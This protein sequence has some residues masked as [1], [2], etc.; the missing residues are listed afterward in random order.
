MLVSRGDGGLVTNGL[1]A[2]ALV[3]RIDVDV[4]DGALEEP[5]RRCHAPQGSRH[6][7]QAHATRDLAAVVAVDPARKVLWGARKISAR[8]LKRAAR[9][10]M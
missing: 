5:R 8:T 7:S 4:V 10:L 9:A 6:W 3:V 1:V 2:A